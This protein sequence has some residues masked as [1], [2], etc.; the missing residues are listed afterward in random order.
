MSL[1]KI[2]RITLLAA[3]T[4]FAATATAATVTDIISDKDTI[5]F[6]AP[7]DRIE[8]TM[9]GFK[10]MPAG[11]LA[12]STQVG[13]W[14]VTTKNPDGLRLAISF[15]TNHIPVAGVGSDVVSANLKS[16]VG[17]AFD[18][19][20]KANGE[21]GTETVT[22]QG[23]KWLVSTA[24]TQEL[25]GLISSYGEQNVKADSYPFVLNAAVYN[26]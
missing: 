12:A 3:L 7:T 17:N 21:D 24:E 8:F 1:S 5:V 15:G 23:A 25:K 26:I 10:S 14:A 9:S 19:V 22:Q 16:D 20:L 4:G 13:D 11:E 18:V 2:T 6:G